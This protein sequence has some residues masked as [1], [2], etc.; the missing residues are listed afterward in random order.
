MTEI[1]PDERDVARIGPEDTALI[2]ERLD[3]AKVS[4]L[5]LAG[6]EPTGIGLEDA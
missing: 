1:E 3:E 6:T 5:R 2:V 4:E